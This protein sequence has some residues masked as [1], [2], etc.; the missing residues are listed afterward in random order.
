MPLISPADQERLRTTF[1]EMTRPVKLLFFTQTLGCE[2]CL[3]ARQILDELPVLSEKITIEEVNFILD[4]DRA[5]QYG[6]DRVPAVAIV[7]QDDAGAERDS[8]IRFLGTPAGYEFMSLIQAVLLVGGRPSML[9]E[10]SL[11]LIADVKEP[12]TVHVFTTPTC[13]HC[14]RAVAVAHEMAF[15]NPNITA[16]AVEA[17]E[18]PDLARKYAVTG[19]PKTVVND[20]VEILGALPPDAFVSQALAQPGS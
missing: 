1:A 3:Q 4:G 18:F 2:T 15:A 13:P 16:F 14:P 11:K 8:K 7:G 9:S 6:I 19:V 5:K 20:S 17:T 10:E 12:T